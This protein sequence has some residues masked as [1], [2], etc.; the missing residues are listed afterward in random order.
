MEKDT[1]T[2]NDRSNN[3]RHGIPMS[4]S[5]LEQYFQDF[6]DIEE[7]IGLVMENGEDL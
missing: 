6:A 2:S 1:G 4:E 5:E 3:C 7:S